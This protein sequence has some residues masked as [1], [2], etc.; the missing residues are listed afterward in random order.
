MNT[1]G[2]LIIINFLLLIGAA[3]NL[4]DFY[5]FYPFKGNTKTFDLILLLWFAAEIVLIVV[6]AF[7]KISGL[8]SIRK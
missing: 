7:L 6:W 2:K 5:A 3:V 1:L 8:T 4:P